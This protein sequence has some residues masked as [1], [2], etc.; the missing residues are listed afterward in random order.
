MPINP[1]ITTIPD[2][3]SSLYA[4][5]A[6]SAPYVSM[7]MGD[8]MTVDGRIWNQMYQ[9]RIKT[10]DPNGKGFSRRQ[11]RLEHRRDNHRFTQD[12]QAYKRGCG[13]QEFTKHVVGKPGY[14]D[15]WSYMMHLWH[16]T[17]A[18][19][20]KSIVAESMNLPEQIN[21]LFRYI[22]NDKRD[23]YDEYYRHMHFIFAERHWL[24]RKQAGGSTYRFD[25][26]NA[27]G[28]FTAP[29]RFA[30]QEEGCL[31]DSEFIYVSPDAVDV[32]TDITSMTP[33]AVRKLQQAEAY[34]TSDGAYKRVKLI[35]S[36]VSA[37]Q[38][39][40]ADDFFLDTL[41][42]RSLGAEADA[43]ILYKSLQAK[44]KIGDLMEFQ[45][46]NR[47]MRYRDTGET[48]DAGEFILQRVDQF[49]QI[50]TNADKGIKTIENPDWQ[51]PSVAAFEIW[52]VDKGPIY[53]PMR[54]NWPTNLGHG[55]DFGQYPYAM[56]KWYNV[57]N[58]EENQDREWGY[59]GL[60][61]DLMS[62][63]MPEAATAS[64]V[65][66]RRQPENL[67]FEDITAPLV[68]PSYTQAVEKTR[69]ADVQFVCA[70]PACAPTQDGFS[71]EYPS[72]SPSCPSC[73]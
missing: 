41:K 5:F 64:L 13:P 47:I 12:W 67:G 28:E 42:R 44:E 33:K 1:D 2:S 58:M 26:G 63:S 73:L 62:E 29:W 21:N 59:F 3:P 4:Y 23:T 54:P 57:Q 65:L 15:T 66:V 60:K 19:N 39:L 46:D 35:A 68:D 45:V 51:D 14:S 40:T 31:Q 36:D 53:N 70:P 20:V 56:W 10:Y 72:V 37:E 55:M 27:G 71:Y 25:Y 24:P 38:V 9:G 17:P 48:T 61:D 49:L 32:V 16:Q 6:R 11:I 52:A 8:E 34:S 50:N 30:P 69:C 22:E 18:F 7:L 43:V